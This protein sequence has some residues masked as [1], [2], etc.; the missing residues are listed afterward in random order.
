M[1]PRHEQVGAKPASRFIRS[2]DCAYNALGA[3]APVEVSPRMWGWRLAQRSE[4]RE[5]HAP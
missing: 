1:L 4:D 2:T 5:Q 3:F